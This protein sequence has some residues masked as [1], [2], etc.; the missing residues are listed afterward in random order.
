MR[1]PECGSHDVAK[2]FSETLCNKCGLVLEDQVLVSGK[3]L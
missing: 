1:C 3:M 2:T